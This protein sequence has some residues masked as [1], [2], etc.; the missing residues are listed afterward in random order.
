MV[1]KKSIYKSNFGA[2]SIIFTIMALNLNL[3]YLV[4][5]DNSF[6]SS[7]VFSLSDVNLLIIVLFCI[8]TFIKINIVEK[9]PFQYKFAIIMLFPIVLAITS[10]L[11]SLY[12]YD[13]PFYLGFRAQR[14][15]MASFLLYFPISTLLKEGEISIVGIKK[16]IYVLAVVELFLGTIQYYVSD[17]TIFM[18]SYV[19]NNDEGTR[20][21]FYFNYEYLRLAFCFALFDISK[22]KNIFKNLFFCAWILL[23]LQFVIESR[24]TLYTLLIAAILTLIIFSKLEKFKKIIIFSLLIVSFIAFSF[25][26]VFQ[27][28]LSDVLNNT[29]TLG[30]RSIGRSFYLSVLEM[31][32]FLGGGFINTLWDAAYTGAKMDE[33][34]FIVDNGIF[35]FA[36]EYGLI[37]AIW[38]V[39]LMYK[40]FKHSVIITNRNKDF[41]YL[42]LFLALTFSLITI[43]HIGLND[44]FIVAFICAFFDQ[45][46]CKKQKNSDIL[47][48]TSVDFK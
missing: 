26:E 20:I 35:G 23:Y 15:W 3:F 22:K 28:N 47:L 6:W 11:Q 40:C 37:G 33:Y 18:F 31:Y 10:S 46:D 32:P 38:Y 41:S 17:S 43:M 45:I 13:Q 36:F 42:T 19:N 27:S 48:S 12:L 21:V 24:M 14:L 5:T 8:I 34:I 30:I 25:T 44:G 29:G 1:K 16:L 2:Y 4:D 7:S 9:R 39:V